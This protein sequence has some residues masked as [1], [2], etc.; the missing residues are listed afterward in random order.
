MAFDY[1]KT[2]Q[3]VLEE[4]GGEKNVE[5]LTHCITR[6]RFVLKDEKIPKD[7]QIEK[8][9]GVL[10]VVRQGGQYQIVIG[11]EVSN[12]YRELV[13]I[14]KFE[15]TTVAKGDGPKENI[16]SRLSGFVAGCMTPLLPAMLGCGMI[17]VVLILLTTF[18]LV[19]TTGSTY[20]ILNA[21]GDA[22][23]YFMPVLLAMTTAKRLGSNIY[24][25][26][27][28]GA[29]LIHP[30]IGGLLSAGNASYFGLPVTSA[31]YSSSVLPVLL[32]VPLMGYIERFA[33]K[34]CPS[35][36][37]VFLKPLIV[38]FISVPLA[39]VVVGPIGSVLGNYLANGI[40]LLY[41]KAGW[42]AIMLL[43]AG[44]PFIIMTG[45]HYALLPIA[46]IG[47]TSLGFDAVL[48][49]TMFCS[50]LAQG[51]ASLAVAVKNKNRDIKSTASAAGI[52]AIIAGVTE[53]SMY[54]V[55]LKYKTPMVASVIG[56]GV[57]GFYAGIT[58][59]VA[60]SMGGS[61]SSLSLIQ[62]IG[63][64]GFGNVIN[65]VITLVISLAVTF[66]MTLI[67]YKPETEEPEPVLQVQEPKKD[68][69]IKTIELSSPL[70]GTVLPLTEV[71][72][73]V[74]S[75]G[76]LGEGVAIIPEEGKVFAPADGVIDAV[77]DTRHAIGITTS[78]GLELLI[79]VGLDTVQ[80]NGD[81]FTLHC[82]MGDPV[83]KGSLLLEFD[84]E[85]IKKAGCS[86]TTPVLVSNMTNFVSLKPSQK[87][88]VK[89][90]D[91]LLTI[92]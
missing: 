35:L 85:K 88:Q 25:A 8:I 64:E 48:V 56:A 19:D 53:P 73:A 47:I 87:S 23:F 57:A 67:L 28:V 9:P 65:G 75:G 79:H 45:M 15:E 42:L 62:M 43:S 11:N 29:F 46:T 21:A 59:V 86:L 74:F 30:D 76:V 1:A 2:A 72:D 51:A 40:S 33:D 66:I 70:T 80:L 31:T 14:G 13:K 3:M 63:G 91:T 10:R 68:V 60:Y 52:S 22:F 69:L 83:K 27:V 37:K 5:G 89:A 26:M 50:N 36:V 4:V 16:F 17:K 34:I 92:V 81:G 82:K 78:H 38:I 44:M 41:S 32:I 84:M 6:L 20:V 71:E 54:G 12:V 55:T 49:V 58:H 61:P 18:H 90:G 24:L 39:L 77:T 7:A